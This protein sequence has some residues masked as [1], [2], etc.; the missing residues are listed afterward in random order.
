[1]SIPKTVAAI[2][3]I[4]QATNVEKAYICALALGSIY[5]TTPLLL[6]KSIKWVYEL[7]FPNVKGQPAWCLYVAACPK[8]ESVLAVSELRKRVWINTL[9]MESDLPQ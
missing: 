4:P 2:G 1:M 5:I 3:Q 7:C 9:G 8:D 6:S